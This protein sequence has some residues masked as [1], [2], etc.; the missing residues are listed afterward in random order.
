M[1]A[2][3]TQAPRTPRW[4][5]PALWLT[6]SA[7]AAVLALRLHPMLLHEAETDNFVGRLESLLR[8]DPCLNAYHPAHS[9]L[10]G[11][12]VVLLS[13]CDAFVALK[14]VSAIGGGAVVAA[15]FQLA[16]HLGAGMTGATLAALTMALHPGLLLL[17]MQAS[18]DALATALM[19][20]TLL[21][22]LRARRSPGSGNA[23]LCGL[24]FG[25]A[26][27][28]RFS[29]FAFAPALLAVCQRGHVVARLLQAAAGAALGFLPHGLLSTLEFGSPFHTENWRN[30]VLKHGNF[31]GRLL[32]E[33]GYPDLLS[34][35]REHWFGS[36]QLGLADIW[37]QLS[38]TFGVLLTSGLPAPW[39]TLV[40]IVALAAL[41]RLAW[42]RSGGALVGLCCGSYLFLVCISYSPI[43]RA[44]LPLLPMA[45]L[46]LGAS[47]GRGARWRTTVGAAALVVTAG[48]LVYR[49]PARLHRFVDAHPFHEIEVARA[50]AARADVELL[51]ATY[52]DMARHVPGTVCPSPVAPGE[53]GQVDPYGHL[54]RELVRIGANAFVI[55]RR[56][57]PDTY[58]AVRG[59]P[60][61]DDV[62]VAVV[63][64]DT[65]AVV[66]D[67]VLAD[68]ARGD[69]W[70]AAFAVEPSDGRGGPL[71]LQ[72][73][74]TP[75]CD[76]ALVAAVTVQL[77]AAPNKGPTLDLPARGERRWGLVW[78]GRLPPGSWTIGSRLRLH[79]GRYVRGPRR[80]ITA[81]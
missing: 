22:A 50:M 31:D 30:F 43:E 80:T 36:L 1:Q 38:G 33:P 5:L 62:H 4:I 8:G 39:S 56:S 66:F 72:V 47:L 78:P 60:A 19:L 7:V 81:H 37:G 18:A 65:I 20:A 75:H 23:I 55:G 27:G 34:F 6:Y 3:T 14:L 42:V 73:E 26:V 69:H 10:C 70:F 53:R 76:L 48:S 9:M 64:D 12:L 15:T 67:V 52:A 59:A 35:L 45:L 79:D 71:D 61:P 29:C 16:R 51:A 21:V 17:S 57:S 58:R 74:L 28:T 41:A 13:G 46:A 2:S 32:R 44:M 49:L 63:D 40:G 11:A 54:R 25:F 77:E 24:V 68:D